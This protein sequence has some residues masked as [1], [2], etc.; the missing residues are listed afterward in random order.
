ML[1]L[2]ETLVN[3]KLIARNQKITLEEEMVFI[4]I[5]NNISE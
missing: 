5:F 2:K 1:A 3:D 4:I